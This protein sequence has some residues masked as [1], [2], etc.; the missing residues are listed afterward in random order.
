VKSCSFNPAGDE[1]ISS[2]PWRTAALP[3]KGG[4]PMTVAIGAD[5]PACF[6]LA[7]GLLQMAPNELDPGM[8]EDSLRELLNM[9]AGHIKRAMA[10]DLALGLPEIVPFAEVERRMNGGG[11]RVA[12]SA[13]RVSLT[14][15]VTK[16]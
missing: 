6:A 4:Q 1:A 8:V 3:I 9:V 11:Q 12:V 10:I 5:E 14:V 16:S 13:G 15:W 7:S 2:K